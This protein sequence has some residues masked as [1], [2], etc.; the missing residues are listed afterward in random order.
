[1][2][3]KNVFSHDPIRI[4]KWNRLSDQSWN[5]KTI[6]VLGPRPEN[7]KKEIQKLT[8]KNKKATLVSKIL[9]SEF[10]ADW[11]EKLGFVARQRSTSKPVVGGDLL[12]VEYEA[13][14]TTG[15]IM[16]PS[17][18][19]IELEL[20][21][22]PGPIVE[23][24]P[25]PEDEPTELGTLTTDIEP[26][27]GFDSEYVISV[28]D[29]QEEKE[30]EKPELAAKA[31]PETTEIEYNYDMVLFPEDKVSELK[32]KINRFMGISIFRQ[33]LWYSV[34]NHRFPMKYTFFQGTSAISVDM[35]KSVITR[36]NGLENIL[37]MPVDMYLYKNKDTLKI[38]AYD[39]FVLL[40]NLYAKSGITEYHLV[41]L[42]TFVEPAR[43]ELGKL[44][45]T[46]KYQIS[47]LYYSFILKYYPQL[48]MAA[49]S[50]YID[51]KNIN[52]SYPT[53][54]PTIDEL[55]NYIDRQQ[56]MIG[57]L[58]ELY[59]TN[60]NR[61]NRIQSV[62]FK[63]LTETTLKVSSNYKG[64]IVNLR[65]L[66]D[67]FELSP[68]IDALRL[69]DVY[70]GKH[71][72][73][74]KYITG[75]KKSTEKLIPG[76][77]Y[78]R[79]VIREHPY[80][81][82]N[83]FLYPNG[84][85]AIKGTWGEDQ[86]YEFNDINAI[87]QRHVSP[88]IKNINDMSSKVMYHGTNI[89]LP[90]I[91]RGNVKFID[92]AI[93]IFWKK[94][95][96]SD[97][98]KQLK[99]VLDR[100]TASRIIVEKQ[101]DR[102]TLTYYFKKGMFEFDPKRIEKSSPLDNY[103]SYLFNSDIRQ[104]W[105]L[106]FENIR[107][108]NISHR[109]SDIKMDISGIKE[110]EY[111]IFI[112]YIVL[113]ISEYLY[114]RKD[115][116]ETESRSRITKPLSNLKEQDPH[117]YNFKKI[118]DSEI[119]YSKICQKPYQP[120]LMTQGQFDNLDKSE[121][122]NVIKYW[123]FTTQSPAYYKC[124]NPKYPYVRFIVGKHPMGY[125]IPCCKITAP[126][127]DKDDKHRRIYD[128]CMETHKYEKGDV[129][130]STSRYIMSYG[131]PIDIGRLSHLPETSLEPLFYETKIEDTE[132]ETEE[133]I[134]GVK[135]YLYGVPQSHPNQSKIGYIYS[136]SHAM[137]VNLE[138][139]MTLVIQKL[140]EHKHNFQML[141]SGSI[142]N[143]F[144][145][146]EEL[147]DAIRSIFLT[148]QFIKQDFS[149]WNELFM[150][151]A[152]QYLEVYTVVFED[153]ETIIQL[154]IPNFVENFVDLQY[155]NHRH[156]FVLHN[157]STDNWNPIYIIHKDLYFR[158]GIID[159]KLFNFQSDVIQ[160]IMDILKIKFKD[161]IVTKLLTF[162]VLKRFL[163][164][165]SAKWQIEKLLIARDNLCYGVIISNVGF[166]PLH[167]SH[168]K[169]ASTLDVSFES[170]DIEPPKIDALKSFITKYNAFVVTQ[171]HKAGFVKIDVPL[172]RPMHERVEPIYPIL[173]FDRW[174]V[175]EKMKC[176]AFVSNGLNF[177]IQPLD[178]HKALAINS[179][180]KFQ[181]INYDP[182]EVNRLLEKRAEPIEDS[183]IK[184]INQALYSK[185]TYQ[186]LVLEFIQ[187][188][189]RQRNL[190]IRE[191]LKKLFLKTNF[192]SLNTTEFFEKLREII[193]RGFDSTNAML[194][195]DLEKLK[196]QVIEFM[197]TGESSKKLMQIVDAEYYNFDKIV[198]ERIKQLPKQEIRTQLQ[199]LASQIVQSGDVSN[200][201][202]FQFPNILQ[203]C[204]GVTGDRPDYCSKSGKLIIPKADLD[205]YLDILSDQI[206]N[207]FIEK[208]LFS[209]LF[210]NSMIDYFKFTKR[211]NEQI[212]IEF[213]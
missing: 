77:L 18:P 160:L 136:L 93:S 189:N 138:S 114:F 203:N 137:G 19:L 176:V 81:K 149:Q 210:Q 111:Y 122:E 43:S 78:F 135:Y 56:V 146:S 29:I 141:L 48:D 74:D 209:P 123:N 59:E 94:I 206:K 25:E 103:Y 157:L 107:V 140:E 101:L 65:L 80:Q 117:L 7:I 151:I 23:S 108:M 106:L 99:N 49:F 70:E 171:S 183:R 76:V 178:I 68:A 75:H 27:E 14:P 55:K 26:I 60:Q 83:M 115:A 150:D 147:K 72:L 54:C 194:L 165:G 36:Q 113:L 69:Y 41:D 185:Y 2:F 30:E 5:Y 130:R 195:T 188:F 172:S 126:P 200:I 91:E 66:F 187:M 4:I 67:V 37:S 132:A 204:Q 199:K 186:L 159:R 168:F 166:V 61:I 134:I 179:S 205:K 127:K 53:L 11:K 174:L 15:D 152:L 133:E 57:K 175:N 120:L 197:T 95:L 20:S 118:Y 177:Y 73:L 116:P 207:P 13:A 156:L 143:W 3:S 173:T 180:S 24:G 62:L 90:S 96:T 46:D 88:I 142:L 32:Y 158:A 154:Q 39:N 84:A 1:M 47:I 85:Y 144:R 97:E 202:D 10:G 109:F 40:G 184:L 208:Y 201:K 213:L 16:Q 153:K 6:I 8:L 167:L 110:E 89:K 212:E 198:L 45:K 42:E 155:P 82:L 124:P 58:Y 100:F 148:K 139:L 31:V 38:E 9:K 191:S 35:Y 21:E 17:E 164:S 211:D 121:R 162:D 86:N 193:M 102:S 63:S 170:R 105:F 163:D 12:E 52:S 192:K 98:F 104:K 44:N 145:N 196:V 125:C 119:V 190:K 169:Y 92:I 129:E 50:E 182:A 79:I 33:H 71:I 128:T 28:D 112:R 51:D 34:R 22:T 181:K 131:K 64:K 161:E 87:V